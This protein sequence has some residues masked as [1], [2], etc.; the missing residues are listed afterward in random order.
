MKAKAAD[1]GKDMAAIEQIATKIYMLRGHAV[2]F[3]HDLARFYGVETRVLIQAV[4]R[5]IERFPEDFMFQLTKE[6]FEN[7]R[8]HFVM[9]NPKA[10]MGLRRALRLHRTRSGYAGI[11]ATKLEGG[12]NEHQHHADFH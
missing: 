4:K 5:N 6:E 3:D 2:M 1:A 7:W 9:S 10:K 8:S 11:R 12:R